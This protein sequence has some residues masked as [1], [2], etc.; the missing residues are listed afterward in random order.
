MFLFKQNY[1]LIMFVLFTSLVPVPNIIAQNT[2][3]LIVQQINLPP[4]ENFKIIV[5]AG[6]SNMAG[7]GKIEPSDCFP[8]PRV[9]ML[10]KSGHW[11]PAIDPIH[12]DKPSAG[13]GPGREFA[14]LLVET[15]SS[16]AV[17]LVPTACGGCS[18][19]AWVPVFF[20]EQ[21]QSH[22]YDDAIA[23]TRRGLQD[24]T[25]TAILWRQGETDVSIETSATEYEKKLTEFFN[26]FRTE[27]AT[28]NL[29]VLIGELFF[30]NETPRSIAIRSAQQATI[31]KLEH[32]S[33][34]S[35]KG[36]TL[37]QDHVHF[38]R[39]SQLE[40]GCRFFEAFQALKKEENKL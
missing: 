11:L 27:F 30:E 3:K 15:D 12:Y 32:A 8:I 5:L 40:Q 6:Q 24:G 16:I 22:P 18:I 17:G 21:T 33:F 25:L 1:T 2:K 4:K 9:F 37:N 35:S 14:R 7:R 19:N 13:V 31:Q 26:R 34:V 29:P 23:R 39:K 10:D 20:F 28:P 38:D 36:T